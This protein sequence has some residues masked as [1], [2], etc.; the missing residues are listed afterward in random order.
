VK[1]FVEYINKSKNVLHTTPFHAVAQK[2]ASRWKSR[3]SGTTPTRSRYCASRTYPQRDGG[4]HLSGLRAAMTRSLNQYIESNE[5]AK[6]AK[7][8]TSGDDMREGL[9]CVLSIKVRS[10]NSRRRPRT[11]WSRRRSGR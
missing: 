7:V 3:C 9:S 4:T 10:P 6:K 11:S 8:E 5:I 2:D 1:G